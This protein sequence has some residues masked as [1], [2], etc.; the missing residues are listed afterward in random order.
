MLKNLNLRL[1]LM[2]IGCLLTIVPLVAITVIDIVEN[3]QL[4]K[5]SEDESTKLAFE[6]LENKVTMVYNLAETQHELL[7]QTLKNYLNVA[8]EVVSNNG[9]I[10]TGTKMVYWNTVNQYT[11]QITP[12]KLPVLLNGDTWFGQI[13]KTGEN[14]PIV[15]KVQSL[16]GGVTSTVFQRMN[17]SGDMLRV[18][19][20]VLQ[21]DGSRAIGTYIPQI[22]P[23]GKPN[24]V[25]AAVLAGQTYT[26]R[27]FV[28]D[29]WYITAYAPIYSG[30]RQVIGALYVGIP[31]ETTKTLRQDIL[32]IKVGETG[33]AY[34]LD[35]N[36]NYIISQHGQR[37]GE[38]IWDSKDASGNYFVQDLV[39]TATALNPG[40]TGS[41][42]YPW[43]NKGEVE[44]R[45]KDAKLMYFAP[46]DWVIGV[47]AYQNEVLAGTRHIQKRASRGTFI[48]IIVT[49]FAFVAAFLTWF[50][51][52]GTIAKPIVNASGIVH[53]IAAERDFTLTVPVESKDEIGRMA[54]EL[55]SLT[56][57]LK[58]AFRV[59]DKS[60][61]DVEEHASD[62]SKRASANKERAGMQQERAKSMQ[63][64]IKEMGATAGEVARFSNAQKES[65]T[66]SGENVGVLVNSMEEMNKS[67]QKSTEYGQQVLEAAKEGANAVAETVK[68]MQNIAESSDQI[69][70]IIAVITEI[71]EK[72]DLLA[73][74]AAI[75]AARA[76]EH[77]KGF[78]VVADEVGKLAQR[79]SEAAKEI[80]KHIR[81]SVARVKEGTRLTDD[82][83][84]A[85][86]KIMDGGQTNMEAIAE[87]SKAVEAMVSDTHKIGDEMKD[88]VS[89]SD[90]MEKLTSLQAGRS[91][92]LV[93]ISESS[94]GVA[95]ETVK[96]A[97]AVVGI[98]GELQQLSRT[99]TEEI[100]AFK[101]EAK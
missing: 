1:K 8:Q 57:V 29:K 77:G 25:V 95:A 80:T 55:N 97:G 60:A 40:E 32:D 5:I 74:N 83:Q 43:K 88:V 93:E 67:T 7:L 13:S 54:N 90:E 100:E 73:L 35:S 91:K 12:V 79:S 71:A 70:E 65:A 21:K 37:D 81:D 62:V 68:G 86:E 16:C 64:T 41:L 10:S 52:S 31:V 36:G 39:K 94:A 2:I 19:T 82:S 78:A 3:R 34:V 59:V 87:I 89:R 11:K 51:V 46:W 33:Y 9:G 20:N 42:S 69:T 15:D 27:A 14:V 47:A 53:K 28:V 66:S 17:R 24:Q 6:E 4:I 45:I 26:G 99:L 76:G 38:N 58:T 23:D 61:V 72:T 22:D 92:K 84:L 44:A 101:Y 96:G 56:E 48:L 18:A 75:E 85:L 30:E 50:F 49:L 98:T 63:E